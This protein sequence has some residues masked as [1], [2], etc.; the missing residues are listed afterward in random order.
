M[1]ER[2]ESNPGANASEPHGDGEPANFAG[3]G[4]S[5]RKSLI[6]RWIVDNPPSRRYP[7]YTRA[8]VGE[9]FP[10]P[11]APLDGDASAS[12]TT[13]SPAGATP[14]ERF[15]AFTRDEFDP[16]NN[17]I[18]GVFGGYCYLNVS[19]VADP[20]RAHARASRPRS[21]TTRSSASSPA[22]RPTSRS[23]PTR[24]RSGPAAIGETLQW[25]L[26][27]PDL[28]ELLEEQQMLDEPA[29]RTAP[30]SRRCPT[31]SWWLGSGTS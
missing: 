6:E 7:I 27:T 9:V 22:S 23:P 16:D 10:D 20:R 17:E 30:T 1:I 25:I 31:R 12:P 28:P 26:T 13:P 5:P 19:V 8:N 21:S 18:I 15:G 24:T 2:S 11:V 4:R 3:W 14:S 29:R